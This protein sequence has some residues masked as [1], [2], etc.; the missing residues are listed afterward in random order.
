M[1]KKMIQLEYTFENVSDERLWRRV[2][3]ENGLRDWLTGHIGQ[4]IIRGD[5]INFT[6]GEGD[7]DRAR[8]E[9]VEPGSIVR[10]HWTEED[11]YF[12]FKIMDT[13]LTGDKALIVTDFYEEGN[14]DSLVNL[15]EAQITRLRRV[16]GIALF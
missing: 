9:V 4:V 7:T 6:W 11:S 15:W 2:T 12:E 16:M 14:R 5:Y 10:Y 13:E 8:I 1:A 3:T